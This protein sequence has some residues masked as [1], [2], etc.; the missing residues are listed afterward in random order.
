MVLV[1]QMWSCLRLLLQTIIITNRHMDSS[2]RYVGN[3]MDVLFEVRGVNS[4]ITNALASCTRKSCRGLYIYMHN[5]VHYEP[6]LGVEKN[7]S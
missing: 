6:I 4:L 7:L 3:N 5:G 1:V 2:V